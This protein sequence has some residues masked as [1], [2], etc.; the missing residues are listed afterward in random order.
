MLSMPMTQISGQSSRRRLTKFAPI[1]P[2]APVTTTVA[3]ERVIL[4][5]NI[6]DIFRDVHQQTPL[7]SCALTSVR[8][9]F[10]PNTESHSFG[11]N[12]PRPLAG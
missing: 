4:E 3:P 12:T 1:N 7:S 9:I 5:F 10:S 11:V 8:L 6:T 2:A